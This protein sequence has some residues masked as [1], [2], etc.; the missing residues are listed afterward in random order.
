MDKKLKIF[1]KR[2][3]ILPLIA[4]KSLFQGFV[5]VVWGLA[6]IFL[7]AGLVNNFEQEVPRSLW[8]INS[9]ILDRIGLLVFIFTIIFFYFEFLELRKI[10]AKTEN[11]EERK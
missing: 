11:I 7:L 5:Q 4:I 3:W 10:T 1:L 6:G 8:E 9:I 2:Y